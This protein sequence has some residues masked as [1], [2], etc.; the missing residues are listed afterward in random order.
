MALSTLLSYTNIVLLVTSRG[1]GLKK[2]AAYDGEREVLTGLEIL[3]CN[4]DVTS[5]LFEHPLENGAVITDHRILNPNVISLQAYI[6]INDVQTLKELN[7]Y[8][9]SGKALKIRAGNDVINN[10][11][12]ETKPFELSS[13]SL[14]KTLYSITFK[15]GFDIVP[16]YVGL[17]N[18]RRGSNT[19]RVNSG[20]KQGKVVK[21]SWGYSAF[22]GGRTN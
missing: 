21:R 10:A 6:A 1:T 19:S 8:Y 2:F 14:D 4:A 9:V 11:Y 7:Y 3:K 22:F 20:Q 17:S 13:A 16:V 5:K 15:E 12:I 18:A